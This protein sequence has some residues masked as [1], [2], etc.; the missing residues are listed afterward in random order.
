MRPVIQLA[1]F[2][3]VTTAQPA[4]SLSQTPPSDDARELMHREDVWNRAQVSRDADAL[5]RLWADD[6][7]VAVPH[8][9]VMTRDEA[10]SLY[11]TL[12]GAQVGDLF[13]SLIDTCQLCGAHSFDYLI[14]IQRH[15]RELAARPS[16]WMPW[17]YHDALAQAAEL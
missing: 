1:L 5:D 14:E 13:M 17:N 8:M 4:R 15:A 11:R 6:L 7:E 3:V 16:E 9:A 12:N 2:L 10:S